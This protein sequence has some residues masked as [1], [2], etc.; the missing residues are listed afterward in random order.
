MR[1]A[2]SPRVTPLDESRIG[3]L[4]SLRAVRGINARPRREIYCKL[5][6]TVYEDTTLTLC[7]PRG[8]KAVGF[9]RWE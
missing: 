9:L 4:A 6:A 7:N 8:H 2:Y 5:P 1:E 3:R